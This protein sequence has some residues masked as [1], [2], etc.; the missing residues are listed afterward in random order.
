MIRKNALAQNQIYHIFNK[1]I[2]DYKILNNKSDY[3]RM[4][5]LMRY[6]QIENPPTKFSYFMELKEVQQIG[7]F[8][9][10]DIITRDQ[11]IIVEIIAY[12][13]MST[14]IHLILKQLISPGI[15]DYMSNILN[16]YSRYFNTK[17]ERKGPLWEGKFQNVPVENNEQLIHLTRY[18]HLNP[19]TAHLVERP[20]DWKFSSYNEYI[21][22]TDRLV[23][24]FNNLLEIM[25]KNYKK[26]VND[27]ISYQ[28]EL[29]LIKKH[30]L[31]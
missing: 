10:F 20:Q 19:V 25:P 31:D 9:Y 26:F 15:S 30:L 23:C 4:F 3:E 29:A 13:L 7:F 27:R 6:F 28:R 18:L 11:T 8:N 14:H 12:C 1:S 16:S 5:Y 21:G 22:N 24:Q 2:A 17:H